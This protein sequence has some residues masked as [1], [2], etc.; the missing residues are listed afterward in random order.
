M[1]VPRKLTANFVE[2]EIDDEI[3]LG[4]GPINGIH[5]SIEM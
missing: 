5:S 3:L 1:S 2:T 4:S